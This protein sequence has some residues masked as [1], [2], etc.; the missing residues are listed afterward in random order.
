MSVIEKIIPQTA[1]DLNAR[2]R[3]KLKKFLALSY[4]SVYNAPMEQDS[5][6]QT[7]LQTAERLFAYK[8]YDA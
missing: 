4:R 2:N 5:T 1:R 3:R 6:K 8:G 7:I